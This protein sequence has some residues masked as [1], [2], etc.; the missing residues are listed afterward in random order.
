[1]N[2]KCGELAKSTCRK[3]NVEKALRWYDNAAE[4]INGREGET[5]TLLSTLS[6][7]TLTLRVAVSPHVI[8][9]VRL[10][11]FSAIT[12]FMNKNLSCS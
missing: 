6:R 1:M 8:S 7:L 9:T 4:Q 5:A 11:L 12:I 10:L 3:L 2:R